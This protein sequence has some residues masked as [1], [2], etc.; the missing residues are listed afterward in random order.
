[1]NEG[2]LLRVHND[3]RAIRIQILP[4]R[5]YTVIRFSYNYLVLHK[6]NT[7]PAMSQRYCL[8]MKCSITNCT[9]RKHIQ[10]TMYALVYLTG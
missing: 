5:K 2:T 8:F 4:L 10:L 7:G 1:M 6:E 3:L 9:F